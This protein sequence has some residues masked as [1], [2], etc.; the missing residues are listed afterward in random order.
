[1][2]SSTDYHNGTSYLWE[3]IHNAF[4]IHSKI[5]MKYGGPTREW[6]NLN[7]CAVVWRGS[8]PRYRRTLTLYTVQSVKNATW[9]V[10][11]NIHS[12][13]DHCRLIPSSA[14]IAGDYMKLQLNGKG[15]TLTSPTRI[16]NSMGDTKNIFPF[17]ANFLRAKLLEWELLLMVHCYRMFTSIT[18]IM[19]QS[20]Q[21]ARWSHVPLWTKLPRRV[22][23]FKAFCLLKSLM[24]WVGETCECNLSTQGSK[25]FCR[26][27]TFA[28]FCEH[29]RK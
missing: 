24:S 22:P 1:M 6:M 26:I 14:P 16:N 8:C 21:W 5:F 9:S 28:A 10:T 19:T 27:G 4:G 3:S 7:I 23:L 15:I 25:L 13:H 29:R 11:E 2:D 20:Y 18:S 17:R 12:L